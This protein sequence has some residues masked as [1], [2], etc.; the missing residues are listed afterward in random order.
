MNAGCHQTGDMGDIRHQKSVDLICDG[1][2]AVE[3]DLSAVGT[4]STDD[5]SW[6][7]LSRQSLDLVEIDPLCFPI[8]TVGAV[9]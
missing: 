5:Q 8:D 9:C 7:M 1:A 6:T 4:R 3:V 2:E